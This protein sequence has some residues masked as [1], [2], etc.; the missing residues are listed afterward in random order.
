MKYQILGRFKWQGFQALSRTYLFLRIFHVSPS[1]AEEFGPLEARNSRPS[2]LIEVNRSP[3]CTQILIFT[4]ARTDIQLMS[5]V[6]AI[7]ASGF[8]IVDNQRFIGA[9]E[10]Q[11][12]LIHTSFRRN[13]LI[14][15]D[16]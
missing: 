4:S 3:T 8:S 13:S 16:G 9:L 10:R 5:S 6:I 7:L 15:I 1:P 12:G 2:R 11:C 14:A